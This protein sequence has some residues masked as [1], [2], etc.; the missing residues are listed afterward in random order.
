M[1]LDE[2]I[3]NEL[4]L[5]F[6]LSVSDCC[7]MA[8]RWVNIHFGVNCFKNSGIEYSQEYERYSITKG[9]L[10]KFFNKICIENGATVTKEP[11]NGDI[12]T[13]RLYEGDIPIITAAIK[14][15]YGWFTHHDSGC[16][17]FQ[18]VKV[19]RAYTWEL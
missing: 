14:Y 5:P 16:C 7:G 6:E 10:I 2:F 19:V 15:K 1:T 13:V 18:D 8:N 4:T 9:N 3:K 12:A 17:F 11:K